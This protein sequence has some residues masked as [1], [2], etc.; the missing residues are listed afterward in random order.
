MS[1]PTIPR[2]RWAAAATSTRTGAQ[3]AN[4]SE[5]VLQRVEGGMCSGA[6]RRLAKL[7]RAR[8][9]LYRSQILQVH[10]RLKAIAEIYTMHSFARRLKI[11]VT[12]DFFVIFSYLASSCLYFGTFTGVLFGFSNPCGNFG[13]VAIFLH[14]R[15]YSD[16]F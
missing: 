4:E 7:W 5:P 6:A 11:Q 12:P 14:V 10:M 2:P 15:P 8:S 3:P 16:H 1:T 13:G 9:R